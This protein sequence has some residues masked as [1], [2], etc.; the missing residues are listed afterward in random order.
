M[1]FLIF[2]LLFS[3]Y[4]KA[5]IDSAV[6][7]PMLGVSLGGGLP[8]ADL[9]ERFGPNLKGGL[10]F[11][12]KTKKNWIY[13]LD[14]SLMFGRNVKEDVTTQLKNADGFVTDN[15]G[16]P[17]DLRITERVM[18]V[19]FTGGRVFKLASANPN[20]GLMI[21]IGAGVLQHKISLYDQ[22]KKIAALKDERKAGLDRLCV[23]FSMS[24]FVG[25]LFLSENRYLNFYTGFEFYQA[26][27]TNIR[28]VNYDTGLPDTRKRFDAL[29]GFKF[30]WI[31]PLYKKKPNDFYYN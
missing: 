25:Y 15:E 10:A 17:A 28:K 14:Y 16:Y 11:M 6:T 5:Q 4:G 26:F 9:A 22:Q 1:R 24:Q 27:T 3:F 20:S 7:V 29:G 13:G 18:A 8:F 12:L 21:S 31:L 23:G 2:V 30:G 19:H